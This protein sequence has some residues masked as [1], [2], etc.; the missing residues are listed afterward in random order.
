MIV[1]VT[2]PWCIVFQ[3]DT[4]KSVGG[5]VRRVQLCGMISGYWAILILGLTAYS[6]TLFMATIL[7]TIMAT[8]RLGIGI[9][10]TDTHIALGTWMYNI[11]AMYT[12]S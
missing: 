5:V 6:N 9:Q 3:F 10:H 7:I 8:I 11:I 2:V 4:I 12:V 1:C